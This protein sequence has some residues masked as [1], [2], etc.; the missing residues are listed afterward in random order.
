M[1]RRQNATT[2]ERRCCRPEAKACER[3][4]CRV[5]GNK[6]GRYGCRPT[7]CGASQKPGGGDIPWPGV[8]ELVAAGAP[9]DIAEAL[10]LARRGD[11]QLER[12]LADS[13]CPAGRSP[14]GP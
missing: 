12:R 11:R 2:D 10:A 1:K 4:G 8:M 6:D 9:T 7:R 14:S 5:C 13:A 3:C